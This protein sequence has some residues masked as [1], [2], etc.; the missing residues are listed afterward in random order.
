MEKKLKDNKDLLQDFMFHIKGEIEPK[1]IEKHEN[2]LLELDKE[3]EKK[4]GFSLLVA[5]TLFACPK[6]NVLLFSQELHDKKCL[7]CGTE[8]SQDN[9]KRFP[10]YQ[11]SDEI[12]IVWSSNL[13]FEAYVAGLLRK[14]HFK[15]WTGIHAMGA[16]GILHEVDVLA[17]K[18]GALVICECKTGK[19]SRNNVFNFCTKVNDLKAHVSILAMLGE[20]PEPD[21]RAFLMRNPAIIRLENMGKIPEK[22]VR[23]DLDKRLYLKA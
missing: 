9:V 10:I 20:L 13:W 2:Q 7:S 16:S 12:K 17:I 21:T 6:C 8:V 22:E 3:L 15:T 4:I 14:L 19:V 1:L 11:I 23:A 18:D 5:S